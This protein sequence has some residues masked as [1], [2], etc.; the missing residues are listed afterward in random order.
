MSELAVEITDESLV[1]EEFCT[2]TVTMNAAAWNSIGRTVGP[3]WLLEQ[4]PRVPVRVPSLSLIAA[5]LEKPCPAQCI[6]GIAVDSGIGPDEVCP[7][8][9]GSGWQSVPGARLAER[10]SHVEVK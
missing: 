7:E 4:M 3:T 10:G 2:V 1:P 9:G 6:R 8:C 5:A